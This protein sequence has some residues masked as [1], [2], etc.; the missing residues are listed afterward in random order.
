MGEKFAGR[1]T[2]GG[3]NA[4]NVCGDTN[5]GDINI[6]NVNVCEDTNIGDANISIKKKSSQ[7]DDVFCTNY[8]K[9]IT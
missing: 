9:A 3:G 6:R 8:E 2:L 7:R 5:F 1:Q 4:D